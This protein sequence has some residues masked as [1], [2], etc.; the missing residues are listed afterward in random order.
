[1]TLA[2]AVLADINRCCFAAGFV[3]SMAL[4]AGV[5]KRGMSMDYAD[6]AGAG[7]G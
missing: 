3:R 6:E 1:L 4:K 7:P 2:A 5:R